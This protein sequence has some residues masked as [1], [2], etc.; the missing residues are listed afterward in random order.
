MQIITDYTR[1]AYRDINRSLLNGVITEQAAE[2]IEAVGSLPA[3]PSLTYRSFHV[4]DLPAYV[5]W[6]RAHKQT[7]QILTFAAFS[8]TSRLRRVADR[9]RGNVRLVIQG[10]TGRDIAQF[11]D[12]PNEEETLYLPGLKCQITKLRTVKVGQQIWSVEI[13]LT[14]L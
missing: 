13:E 7:K 12:A 3:L 1:H 14:E 11:S 2:L 5:E 8:S 9:F 4:S 6:L 10:K